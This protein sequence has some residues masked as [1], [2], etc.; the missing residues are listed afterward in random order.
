MPRRPPKH[1]IGTLLETVTKHLQA[2]LA[3]QIHQYAAT[4]G[5][6]VELNATDHYWMPR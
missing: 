5:E 2:V 1:N 3:F 6:G 4:Q